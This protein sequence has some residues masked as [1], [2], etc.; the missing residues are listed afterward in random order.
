MRTGK[1]ELHEDEHGDH[2]DQTGRGIIFEIHG[3]P[4]Y[5]IMIDGETRAWTTTVDDAASLATRFLAA[6]GHAS[7]RRELHIPELP[8]TRSTETVP[9]RR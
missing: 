3:E 5:M 8:D 2:V 7:D 9:C 4:P 1:L 6:D